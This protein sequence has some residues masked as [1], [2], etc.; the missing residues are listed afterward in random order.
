VGGARPAGERDAPG[1]GAAAD[2]VAAGANTGRDQ[3][4]DEK[5]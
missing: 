5:K 1:R 3:D 4:E 2:S